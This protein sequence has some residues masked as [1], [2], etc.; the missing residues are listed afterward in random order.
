MKA[1]RNALSAHNINVREQAELCVINVSKDLNLE[2]VQ[3]IYIQP[4]LNQLHDCSNEDELLNES[5][6][7]VFFHIT[8][9]RGL[10]VCLYV[11]KKIVVFSFFCLGLLHMC[12]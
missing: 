2:T 11:K 12:E 9:S 1:T 8:K 7:R 6:I 3:D 5:Q 10:C 4:M